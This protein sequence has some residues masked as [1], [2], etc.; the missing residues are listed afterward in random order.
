MKKE[1]KKLEIIC[2]LWPFHTES[3]FESKNNIIS[4]KLN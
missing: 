1:Q 3:Y 4:K 2:S